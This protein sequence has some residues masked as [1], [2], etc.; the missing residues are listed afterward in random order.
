M[1]ADAEQAPTP[2]EL[3]LAAVS[4]CSSI[5]VVSILKKSRCKVT[6][7]EVSVEAQRAETIP[8]VFTHIHLIYK[9]RGQNITRRA[10][11]RAVSLSMEKYCS[12]SHMLAG[13]VQI[14]HS[15]EIVEG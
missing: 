7:C 15:V 1:S 9:L 3:V 2:M 10:A 12:V 14:T 13:R 8:R 4:G 5:D 6:A 11:E